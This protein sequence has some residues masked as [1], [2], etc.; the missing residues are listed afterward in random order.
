[1]RLTISLNGA[2]FH[3]TELGEFIINENDVIGLEERLPV[4]VYPM[5]YI[6]P[7]GELT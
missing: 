4:P 7:S 5:Q 3:L 1:V 6:L 2:Q